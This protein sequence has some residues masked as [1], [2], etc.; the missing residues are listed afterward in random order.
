MHHPNLGG[1]ADPTE[2]RREVSQSRRVLERELGHPVRTFA[3][4]YGGWREIGTQGIA[5]A[6]EAGCAWAVATISGTTPESD[7]YLLKRIPTDV[8]EHWWVLAAQAAGVWWGVWGILAR[9]GRYAARWWPARPHSARERPAAVAPPTSPPTP[10]AR[11][12][13]AREE[14]ARAI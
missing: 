5:A 14:P 11:P 9:L 2:A 4:P 6:R 10:T 1:L 8:S 7:R 13:A 12:V 3:Y